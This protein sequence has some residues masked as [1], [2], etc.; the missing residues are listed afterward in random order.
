M[1][2]D[3]AEGCQ[4]LAQMG[5]GNVVWVAH[6]MSVSGTHTARGEPSALE[7]PVSF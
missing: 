6:G 5:K 4:G 2:G 1:E 3:A 7:A